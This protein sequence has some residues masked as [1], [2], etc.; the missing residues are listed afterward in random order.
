MCGLM[1][2]FEIQTMFGLVEDADAA[3]C[4]A[5]AGAANHSKTN[6][7]SIRDMRFSNPKS[8]IP[9][10]QFIS[11]A[12]RRRVENRPG[13]SRLGDAGSADCRRR[14]PAEYTCRRFLPAS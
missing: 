8:L 14:A 6:P 11:P 9:N 13:A 1:S 2:S 4:C 12:H 10:P 3:N 5:E 7:H